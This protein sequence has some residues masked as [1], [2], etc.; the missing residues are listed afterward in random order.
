MY[1]NSKRYLEQHHHV[2]E[3][4]IPAWEKEQEQLQQKQEKLSAEYKTLRNSLNELLNVRYCVEYV[5]KR[6]KV[7][8]KEQAIA[9]ISEEKLR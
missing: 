6:E 9:A 7:L 4:M 1:N 3:I 5:K 2:T 8:C